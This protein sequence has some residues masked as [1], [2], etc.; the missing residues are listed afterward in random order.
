MKIQTFEMS[1]GR[2][3]T[4]PFLFLLAGFFAAELRLPLGLEEVLAILIRG[5]LSE[6]PS[7]FDAED[8]SL[9]NEK[10]EIKKEGGD[11]AETP[12][13]LGGAAFFLSFFI[14]ISGSSSEEPSERKDSNRK[15]K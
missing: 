1:S 5:S 11:G 15:L 13:G 14:F 10:Q 2:D 3:T 4:S 12:P 9:K 6:S 7:E 8:E